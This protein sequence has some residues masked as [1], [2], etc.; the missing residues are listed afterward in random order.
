MRYRKLRI[1]WSVVCGIAGVLLIVLWVRSYYRWDIAAH[2]TRHNVAIASSQA[3]A[4]VLQYAEVIDE[5]TVNSDGWFTENLPSINRDLLPLNGVEV[6]HAGP[7][8]KRDFDGYVVTLPY[9]LLL[10]LAAAFATLPWFRLRFSLRTLLIATT[11]VA[12]V[13][14]LIVAVLGYL[15]SRA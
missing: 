8:Y 10:P 6:A 9:W 2:A 13:L 3:G 15:T 14:G 12:A 1:A 11:L 7:I 5:T 4:L